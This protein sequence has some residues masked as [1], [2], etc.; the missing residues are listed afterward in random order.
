MNFDVEALTPEQFSA[1]AS[2]VSTS[3]P[4]LDDDVYRGLLRQSQDVKP[5]TYRAVRG[6]LFDDIVMRKLPP[7]EGPPRLEN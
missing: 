5:H 2:M 7:G 3:G 4:V 1:W 6:G